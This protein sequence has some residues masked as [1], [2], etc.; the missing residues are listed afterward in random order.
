[1]SHS[2]GQTQAHHTRGGA[3]TFQ[4][5]EGVVCAEERRKDGLALRGAELVA[6]A[7]G[8]AAA[9]GKALLEGLLPMQ[10]VKALAFGCRAAP[11]VGVG[12]Q[13]PAGRRSKG[14]PAVL[15]ISC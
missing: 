12:R 4:G 14:V 2:Q 15:S 3:R 8:A 5:L 11:E 6:T 1:M 7:T 13:G 9:V 10:V